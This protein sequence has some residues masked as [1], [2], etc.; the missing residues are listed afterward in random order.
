MTLPED[1]ALSLLGESLA[2]LLVKPKYGPLLKTPPRAIAEAIALFPTKAAAE[3]LAPYMGHA[4][5][6]PIVAEFFHDAPKLRSALSEIAKGK[7]KAADAARTVLASGTKRESGPVASAEDVPRVLVDRPW[8]PRKGSEKVVEL[9]LTIPSN[10]EERIELTR[11]E[12]ELQFEK[13][14]PARDMTQAEHKAWRAELKENDGVA[15]ADW[16]YEYSKTGSGGEYLRIPR[17]DGLR[18]WN[19]HA[20]YLSGTYVE[21]LATHGT[22]AISGFLNHDWVKWLSNQEVDDEPYVDVLAHIVSP[23]IAP[24]MARIVAR[25]KNFRRPALAWLVAHPETAALGLV[26]DALGKHGEARTDAE[27]ALSLMAHKGQG[28]VVAKVAHAYSGEAGTAIVALL[29]RDPLAIDKAPPKVPDFL[30]LGEL[31]RVTTKTGARLPDDAMDALLEMLRVAPL[32]PPYPGVDVVRGACDTGSLGELARAL[33]EQW[34]LAGSPGRCEW[35]L[36]SAS[37]FPSDDVTRRIGG[38]AREWARRD[39][40]KAPRACAVLAA[41]GTDLALLHVGHIAATSR[42]DDVRAMAHSLLEEAAVARELTFAELEDR[43]V[44]DLD[45]GA[46]GTIALSFGKR[47]F[48]VD[49]DEGLRPIVRGEKTFPRAN[50]DDDAALAKAARARFDALK[51]DAAAVADRQIR[52]FEQAMVNGRPWSAKDFIERVAKHPL[53]VHL[54]RR[55]VWQGSKS[56]RVAEDGTFS[57]ASDAVVKLEGESIRIAHPARMTDDDRR[58]WTTLFADYRVVQPFEQLGRAVA[59]ASGNEA[60]IARDITVAGRK[61]VGVLEARGW[62]RNDRGHVTAYLRTLGAC[63]EARIEL[64]PGVSMEDVKGAEDQKIT[65]A[66]LPAAASALDPVDY[67]EIARDLDALL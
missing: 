31:P 26:P 46:D 22:A 20:M 28:A 61:V 9:R 32:D 50:K 55:L 44:P 38:I 49:L 14:N 59:R 42:F 36:F 53:L 5:L 63:G 19:E 52:R 62:R 16:T 35:M 25:R 60:R 66:E 51:A 11:A 40:K 8:R 1:E 21:F 12:R 58:A 10:A 65:G 45:L 48:V 7:T 17:G 18:A 43:I 23:R 34:V 29:A 3:I 39:R 30:R 64:T 54:A 2:P 56:F 13:E 37:H 41:I 67:A 4:I 6:G 47:S 33:V 24:V 57:D 15:Y 27:L